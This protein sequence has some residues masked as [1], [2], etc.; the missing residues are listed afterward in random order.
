MARTHEIKKIREEFA[1]PAF[2]KWMKGQLPQRCVYC[3]SAEN[4]EYHH[5]VPVELGGD[6]RLSNIVPLCHAHHM[7]ITHG[8]TVAQY[9]DGRNKGGRPR[10]YSYADAKVIFDDFS[11]GRFGT[12][13]LRKRMHISGGTHIQD[14]PSYKQYLKERDIKHIKSHVDMLTCKGGHVKEFDIL[15]TIEYLDGR[16]EAVY[17]DGVELLNGK[18]A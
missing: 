14:L 3:G 6:N 16:V 11:H 4:L 12:A 9:K 7:V 13:E 18:G 10:K 5:L 2:R 8:G 1:N 15:V 17:Q